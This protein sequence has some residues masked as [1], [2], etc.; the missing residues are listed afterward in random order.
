MSWS[1]GIYQV[2]SWWKPWLLGRCLVNLKNVKTGFLR[3]ANV[4]KRCGGATGTCSGNVNITCLWQWR[5]GKAWRK[6]GAVEEPNWLKLTTLGVPS[7]AARLKPAGLVLSLL[8][9]LTTFQTMNTQKKNSVCQY[10]PSKW[11]LLRGC[12]AIRV[13]NWDEFVF[14]DKFWIWSASC[15]WLQVHC[16]Q[17]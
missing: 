10:C 9:T 3:T 4:S 1:P 7:K 8:W 14:V 15:Y 16:G 6:L 5:F 11:R 13:I 12:E 17:W 2:D